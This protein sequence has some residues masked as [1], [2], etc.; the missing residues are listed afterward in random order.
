M[1]PPKA[2]CN[3]FFFEASRAF[4][5]VS[6]VCTRLLFHLLLQS[7]SVWFLVNL[8]SSLRDDLV[9]PPFSQVSDNLQLNNLTIHSFLSKFQCHITLNIVTN[10][11]NLSI[12]SL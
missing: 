5:F 4:S 7:K 12:V 3:Y 1:P 9:C 8:I 2:S 6:V 10:C 11:L